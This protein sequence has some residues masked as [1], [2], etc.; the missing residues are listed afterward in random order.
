M[1]Q[2]FIKNNPNKFDKD[3]HVVY[4]YT[5]K[6]DLCQQ[7]KNTYIGQTTVLLKQRAIMHAQKGAILNH[8]M[9]K[10]NI[11]IKTKEILEDTAI[12]FKSQCRNE[13]CIAESLFIKQLRPIMN[14]QNEGFNRVLK[15]F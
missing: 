10:H 9:N 2:L 7:S 3:S 11:K 13:L 5:C 8:N 6:K 4:E 1:S 12:L 14:E 15:I